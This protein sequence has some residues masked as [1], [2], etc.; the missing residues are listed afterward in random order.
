[1]AGAGRARRLSALFLL[2]GLLCALAGVARVVI[3]S[4]V[5]ADKAAPPRSTVHLPAE[6]LT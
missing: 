1:M 5:G 2:V 4:H 3:M 6:A